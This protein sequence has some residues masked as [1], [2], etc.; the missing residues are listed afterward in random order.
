MGDVRYHINPETGRANKCTAQ[1]KCKYTS[2]SGRE[3]K[4]YNSKDEALKGAEFILEAEIMDPEKTLSYLGKNL[5]KYFAQDSTL[6]YVYDE[7]MKND[8]HW[9]QDD[10]ELLLASVK[11]IDLLENDNIDFNEVKKK[12][13]DMPKFSSYKYGRNSN[14]SYRD[15]DLHT[16]VKAMWVKKRWEKAPEAPVA[17]E[18]DRSG[19]EAY[20]NGFKAAQRNIVDDLARYNSISFGAEEYTDDV[21]NRLANGENFE[22]KDD[23]NIM[24]VEW[25][26]RYLNPREQ[27]FS[28]LSKDDNG[29]FNDQKAYLAIAFPERELKDALKDHNIKNVQVNT[30]Y[31]NRE[32]GNVY[33]VMQPDGNTRSF[34]V[35]EHRNSDSII[36]NGSTN[37]NPYGDELPYAGERKNQFFTEVASGDMKRAAN[38]L[39]FFLKEAQKGDLQSD[40]YLVNNAEKLDWTAILSEKIPGFK[41]WSDKNL[42][43]ENNTDDPRFDT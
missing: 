18:R 31:N 1:Y 22:S 40:E 36:I 17:P 41:E 33:T 6:Q 4:H 37:W 24:G 14:K 12:I 39:A 13:D 8:N 26:R 10:K 2:S 38:T 30:F 23:Y 9:T 27:M 16:L 3:P 19:M 11:V 15:K 25:E 28:L 35:Y 34:S 7:L 29:I 21:L 5:K 43:Q 20:N 42:P 32:L